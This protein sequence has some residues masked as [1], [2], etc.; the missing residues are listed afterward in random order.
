M[1]TLSRARVAT[2]AL[3]CASVTG[4]GLSAPPAEVQDVEFQS[5]SGLA[6]TAVAGADDYT[7]YRG[8]V[9]A[10]ATTPG[11]CHGD[12]I[13]ATTFDSPA[14]P[15]AGVGFFYLVTAESDLDGEGT[16]GFE[17][18]G[19][20]RG[21]LGTCDTI[22]RN[23]VLSRVTYGWDEWSRDRLATLGRQGFLDEQLDPDLIDEST[24]TALQDR[25]TNIE[26]PE[27]VQEL[28]AIQVVRAVY[29]HRQLEQQAAL[30]W[31]NHFNTDYNTISGFFNV[32]ADP[33]RRR[34]E[35]TT[36]FYREIESFR[37]LAF[38]GTF[39]EI[40][41]ASV[42]SPAMILYLDNDSNVVGRPNENL[43][44]EFLEL[45]TMGVDNGYTQTDVEEVARVLTGWNVCKKQ[46]GLVDD[47]L[48]A[49]IPRSIIDTEFEPNGKWV[50]NFNFAQHDCEAK[51]IFAG[52]AYETVIG[53]TCDGVGDP[54]TAGVN[55]IYTVIDAVVAHPSTPEFIS[56][57]MLQRWVTEAPPQAMIDA[58]VSEW[59]DG[60]NPLGVGDLQEVLRAV[61]S[62]P[63]TFAP[64]TAGNKVRTPFE[65][66]AAT[67]RA[68]R[69]NTDGNATVR[70]YLLRMQQLFFQNPIP[71]GYSEFGDDWLDTNNV[72]ERQNFGAD[73]SGR[74]GA[75]FGGDVIGL[76]TDNGV[77]TAQGNADAIVDFFIDALYGGALSP[78]ERQRAIDFLN[79]DNNGVPSNY[80]DAR[81]R[82]TVGLLLG[83]AQMSEQ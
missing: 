11:K 48:A 6:W 79:T 42:L 40:A 37:D 20:E 27:T 2:V 29:G 50:R 57:K 21:L 69:G 4:I 44:R 47:P 75:N 19:P 56:T 28:Q 45:S 35:T 15:E 59:N 54:T 43:A 30:F 9:A 38:G 12:E 53:S 1:A 63:E 58:I 51:T 36:L 31:E 83:F 70:G 26:P 62:Q 46:A 17:S 73:V 71:T 41:E 13:V 16:P 81:I 74:T 60:T 76:L 5:K 52:T 68:I 82:D 23:H 7:V 32:Y 80:N 25:L 67:F 77:S 49:C 10:V 34:L 8:E 61:L 22:L 55:D 66:V 64:D 14:D 78:G 3:V 33:V 72:L 39:R 24:N 18:A 65:F